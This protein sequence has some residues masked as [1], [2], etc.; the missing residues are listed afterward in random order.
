MRRPRLALESRKSA[1]VQWRSKNR[2]STRHPLLF[3]MS[4]WTVGPR[5]HANP[6]SPPPKEAS[7]S[8]R[9]LPRHPARVGQI[10]A[11][12]AGESTLTEH[13]EAIAPHWDQLCEWFRSK[14]AQAVSRTQ[15]DRAKK[16]ILDAVGEFCAEPSADA[17]RPAPVHGTTRPNEKAIGSQ[18]SNSSE[19]SALPTSSKS[20]SPIWEE[21]ARSR[22]PQ[23]PQR[24]VVPASATTSRLEASS[25]LSRGGRETDIRFA[26]FLIKAGLSPMAV[27]S[28][29]EIL[30]ESPGT[31]ASRDAQTV[32]D[33]IAKK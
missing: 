19:R 3:L 27:E 11:P 24:T 14:A 12:A 1:A 15:S 8:K 13:N 32:L 33:S 16:T 23:S 28:L 7:R 2:E 25:Q 26:R 31:Q 6:A 18:S 4:V 21:P 22:S 29:R 17:P 30:K 20:A 10:A 5:P 9:F